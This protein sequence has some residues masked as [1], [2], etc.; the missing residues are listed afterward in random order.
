LEILSSTQPEFIPSKYSPYKALTKNPSSISNIADF[1]DE[2]SSVLVVKN[3]GKTP[4]H[5][6]VVSIVIPYV[7]KMYLIILFISERPFH[8][9]LYHFLVRMRSHYSS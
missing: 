2:L 1:G 5:N 7:S 9:S 8:I 6:L 3:V 4:A